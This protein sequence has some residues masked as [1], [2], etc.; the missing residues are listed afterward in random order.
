MESSREAILVPHIGIAV[1]TLCDIWPELT[2]SVAKGW[3]PHMAPLDSY[4]EFYPTMDPERQVSPNH[5]GIFV[6][7][8]PSRE[9]RLL[10]LTP[11]P[12]WRLDSLPAT[13]IDTSVAQM[14]KVA[15][16]SLW[17]LRRRSS[18]WGQDSQFRRSLLGMG[19]LLECSMY[20]PAIKVVY[21]VIARCL[22]VI[23]LLHLLEK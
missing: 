1:Q 14:W 3:G 13:P 17:I 15:V 23:F 5:V 21:A 12:F 9:A 22:L 7:H 2:V 4:G 20:G 18:V 10:L 6:V 19:L 16:S 8:W 11:R